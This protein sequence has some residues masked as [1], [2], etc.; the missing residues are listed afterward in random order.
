[1]PIHEKGG[2]E[3]QAREPRERKQPDAEPDRGPREQLGSLRH[4]TSRA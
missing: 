2:E 4:F 3:E 1:V